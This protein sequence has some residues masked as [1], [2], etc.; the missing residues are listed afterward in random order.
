MKGNRREAAAMRRLLVP[1]ILSAAL[2]ASCRPVEEPKA[3]TPET[4]P[5]SSRHE[6]RLIRSKSPYLLQH[7]H[8]P[9]D[10]YEWSDEAF[11]K[12]RREDKPL[13]VSIG[14][15]TC[16][17]CH[18][19]EHESFE[20]E[21]VARA[22]NDAWV[23]VKVDREERPDLD[24]L[25]MTVC[26][27]M[28]GAGGWPL[29]ILMTPDRK[30]F[31]AATYIPKRGFS[32]RPGM[33]DLAP[34]VREMWKTRRDEL[35][36]SADG[37]VRALSEASEAGRGKPLEAWVLERAA[38]QFAA[39]FDR[40]HGGFGGA[41]KFPSPHHLL[42]LLRWAKRSGDAEPLKM[43]ERTLEAMRLGGVYDQ[44]G[45][46][47]H[48]YS[49][50]ARWLVPHFEKMLYD[51]AMLVMAYTEAFQATGKAEYER[52][53]REVIEYVLRDMTSPEGAF[54]SGE[55]ADS[56]GVEGKF[57]TWTEEEIRRVL[58]A[59]AEFAIR[60]FGVEKDGNF[61]EEATRGR[62]GVNILH[63]SKPPTDDERARLG[64]ARAKLFAARAT[65]VRP[66]KDDKVLA[67]WNGLMI[68]ALAKAAWAFDEPRYAEAAAR[69]ADFLLR[70]LTTPEGRLL[71]RYRDG[72]AAIPGFADDYAFAVWG[73]VDLYEA[74][75]DAKWLK[76]ALTLA[77]RLEEHFCDEKG[78]G[79]FQ[80]AD[81]AEALLVRQKVGI[82]GAMPSGNSAAALALLRLVRLTGKTD[83]ESAA[84]GTLDAFAD[85]ARNVPTAFAMMLSAADFRLGPTSE[86][87]VAGNP[88]ADDTRAMLRALRSRFLPGTVVLLRPD[89]PAPPIVRIAPF[90]RA[91]TALG[92]KATAYVCRNFAC[93]VPTN[94]PAEMLR[95][96]EVR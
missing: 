95:Q 52:T 4:P 46:G 19:M 49:V 25:Y 15:S 82:D 35:V 44:V 56:E 31:F 23:S 14:Y 13:F 39:D 94:D 24:N 90:S 11:E 96:L 16:H 9:V 10:W 91:Q 34:A 30:P 37:V 41:P 69:A 59:D 42:F 28:T 62:A 5:G 58:G 22:M 89:E 57:Y 79:F 26:Q 1:F 66:H 29:N 6:N 92:G 86:V 12:A 43:V 21:E 65:R 74:T 53:A 55:D 85:S 51:Q 3:M 68:A 81:D 2:T 7:A 20:D 32:G 8:N 80:T 77:S 50:D 48:R 72:E 87:V 40:A 83:L 45:F 64:A 47:F 54:Y 71:H 38:G 33:L 18:V 17:W 67:D 88:D 84:A 63:L 75:F 36:A 70:T 78:G 76:A 93:Q 61:E 60:A 73:L 27:A